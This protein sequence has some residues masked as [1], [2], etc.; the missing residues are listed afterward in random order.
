M[1]RLAILASLLMT[2]ATQAAT[3]TIDATATAP[4]QFSI[5]GSFL[6]NTDA[7]GF[8]IPATIT[9]VT[10]TAAIP[11]QPFHFD[12]IVLNSGPADLWFGYSGCG[13]AN[14]FLWLFLAA[15]GQGVWSIGGGPHSAVSQLA[16]G[17]SS[18]AI[19][20]TLIDPP[21]QTETPLPAALPMFAG[22]LFGFYFLTRRKRI[23]SAT[24]LPHGSITAE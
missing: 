13:I 20:G 9:N 8:V 18:W 10:I 15:D 7:S 22:G 1:K 14:C 4:I 6:G 21:T 23:R 17:A 11:N 5:A 3:F 12:Q 19:T 24:L 2:T 16:V